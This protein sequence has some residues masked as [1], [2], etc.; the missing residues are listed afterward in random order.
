MLNSILDYFSKWSIK[1]IIVVTCCI[2]AL[3]LV[4]FS[5][6]SC[7]MVN[8]SSAHGSRKVEKTVIQEQEWNIPAQS[9]KTRTT[10]TKKR[11]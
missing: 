1:K 9:Y 4:G 6:T 2:I 5:F 8:R 10:T 3:L 11:S 7:A